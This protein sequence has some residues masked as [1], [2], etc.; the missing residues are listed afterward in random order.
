MHCIRFSFQ[1][2]SSYLSLTTRRAHLLHYHR[3][4]SFLPLL[5]VHGNFAISD[6]IRNVGR[7][8][9]VKAHCG[10]NLG[11]MP[12]NDGRFVA[13]HICAISAKLF[14][15]FKLGHWCRFPVHSS[16]NI[17]HNVLDARRLDGSSVYTLRSLHHFGACYCTSAQA[18]E[19]C[20]Y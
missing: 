2:Q 11:S 7:R 8:P 20:L 10:S 15:F 5:I 6:K 18:P 19:L 1:C 9:S 13:L 12:R 17:G 14:F 3:P 4:S 16:S